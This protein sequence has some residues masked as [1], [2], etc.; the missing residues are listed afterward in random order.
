MKRLRKRVAEAITAVAL[1]AC[2]GMSSFAAAEGETLS[3]ILYTVEM[4]EEGEEYLRLKDAPATAEE[5]KTEISDTDNTPEKEEDSDKAE[6]SSNAATGQTS[7]YSAPEVEPDDME[8]D[9]EGKDDAENSKDEDEDVDDEEDDDDNDAREINGDLEKGGKNLE[10]KENTGEKSELKEKSE[11]KDETNSKDK[12]EPEN[13]DGAEQSDRLTPPSTET[14]TQQ[15]GEPQAVRADTSESAEMEKTPARKVLIIGIPGDGSYDQFEKIVFTVKLSKAENAFKT[16]VVDLSGLKPVNTDKG[17]YYVLRYELGEEQVESFLANGIYK[18]EKKNV[19]MSDKGKSG[20]EQSSDKE[21]GSDAEQTVSLPVEQGKATEKSFPWA[22]VIVAAVLA[23]GAAGGAAFFF[24]RNR[25]KPGNSILDGEETS[26]LSPYSEL[27]VCERPASGSFSFYRFAIK[28]RSMYRLTDLVNMKDGHRMESV[29]GT[30][31]AN[32]SVQAFGKELEVIRTMNNREEV[33]FTLNPVH[34]VAELVTK[35]GSSY[36][37]AWI[38][39]S[40]EES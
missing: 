32:L 24:L 34:S 2:I 25:Q 39:G 31:L 17:K 36:R 13:K 3:P 40:K 27:R 20:A 6:S 11:S 5:E 9:G 18:P 26:K 33:V 21:P 37:F 16:A 35:D 4:A 29:K 10:D 12:K 28:D 7:E 22:I 8:N 14:Q 30:E 19:E 23:I 38:L 1:A 15:V